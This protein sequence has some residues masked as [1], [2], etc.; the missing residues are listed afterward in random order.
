MLD[1]NP[2]LGLECMQQSLALRIAMLAERLD[3]YCDPSPMPSFHRYSFK[4]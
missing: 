4:P 1:N 3:L 2:A